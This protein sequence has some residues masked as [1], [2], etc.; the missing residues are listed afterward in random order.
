[1]RKEWG[2]EKPSETQNSNRLHS[3]LVRVPNSWDCVEKPAESIQLARSLVIER[4]TRD[5]EDTS[6]NPLCGPTRRVD[7]LTE[8][9]NSLGFKSTGVR[10][11]TNVRPRTFLGLLS[12]SFCVKTYFRFHL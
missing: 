3:S 11:M 6:S 2:V 7:A 9:G 4:L 12:M 1:M 5:Q 10:K 8:G